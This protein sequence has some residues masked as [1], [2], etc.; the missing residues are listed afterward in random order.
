MRDGRNGATYFVYQ[1]DTADHPET[2][3]NNPCTL[4]VGLVDAANAEHVT[5]LDAAPVVIDR[6]APNASDPNVLDVSGI[7]HVRMPFGAVQSNYESA[8]YVAALDADNLAPLDGT[9]L[10]AGLVAEEVRRVRFFDAES[11]GTLQSQ[12]ENLNAAIKLNS[13]DSPEL[14]A[15]VV[16]GAGNISERVRVVSEYVTRFAEADD[17]LTQNPVEWLRGGPTPQDFG[18]SVNDLFALKQKIINQHCNTPPP[19]GRNAIAILQRV[20]NTASPTIPP[21]VWWFCLGG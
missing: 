15:E 3:E 5:T 13:T 1:K 12:S 11:G 21:A 9:A 16:D 4:T 8:Q 20:L 14:F 17:T 7:K 19:L 10:P 6:T 18:G 2:T